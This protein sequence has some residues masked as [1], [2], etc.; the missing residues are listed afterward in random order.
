MTPPYETPL[1]FRCRDVWVFVLNNRRPRLP[2]L[3]DMTSTDSGPPCRRIRPSDEVPSPFPTCL[4]LPAISY[5]RSGS[6]LVLRVSRI[7]KSISP[8][9][10]GKES[11]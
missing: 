10:H 11:V 2:Q 1:S 7:R 5:G 4:V 6:T 8:E 9:R 3:R